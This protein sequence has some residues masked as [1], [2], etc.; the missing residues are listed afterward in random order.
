MK[1]FQQKGE[2]FLLT[3]GFQK[4]HLPFTPPRKYWDLYD[5]SKIALAPNQE[6]AAGIPSLAFHN[7]GELR[8]YHDIPPAM[9]ESGLLNEDK[10]RELIHG[11]YASI[12]Y[13]DAQIGLLLEH[14]KASGL[15][16]NTVIVLT[17]DH[18]WH[19]GDHG[20]WNKHSNFEQA[21]RTPLIIYAPE[22]KGGFQNESP[23]ELI[24]IFSTICDLA[25]IEVPDHLHGRS[26]APILNKE[27][28]K[29]K[30]FAI[31]QYPRKCKIGSSVIG[32]YPDD[33]TVMGYAIRN[34]RYRYVAWYE[35]DYEDRSVF[36]Q[37]SILAEELYDYD[38]DP[39]EQQNLAARPNIAEVK[40]DL[41][42]D[43]V[44]V[45]WED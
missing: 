30:D 12:S 32:K 23:V 44:G 14:L 43:L 13:I 3:I 5:R 40:A 31:S 45:I 15:D 19:L 7:S 16:E 9:N 35:G 25:G 6:Q 33:C 20:L 36:R 28:P 38:I 42:V 21:T 26:L 34:E 17:G 10:Q 27:Q 24:D 41:L 29:V 4:P 2:K 11:Y 8:T 37:E 39:L 1:A 18:G 22:L